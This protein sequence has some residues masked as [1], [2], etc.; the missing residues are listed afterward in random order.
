MEKEKNKE[1]TFPRRMFVGHTKDSVNCERVVL[2]HLPGF[3]HP[4]ITVDVSDEYKY[5]KKESF[6]IS[7]WAYAQEIPVKIKSDKQRI[8][9]L[10]EN[11][12]VLNEEINKL[13]NSIA[14]L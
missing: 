8:A 13:T 9:D 14:N 3:K 12:K 7:S 4:F 2:T 6:R 5:N 1:L 11:I 10:E